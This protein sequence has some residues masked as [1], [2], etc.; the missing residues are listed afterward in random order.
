VSTHKETLLVHVVTAGADGWGEVTAETTPAYAPDT[1][2]SARLV[3]RNELV[4]R[5]FAGASFDA[6]R[7]N[8]AAI[9]ALSGALLDAQLRTDEISLASYLGSTRTRVDAGVAIG[10]SDTVAEV[11]AEAREHVGLGYRSLKLKVEPGADIDVV[12]AVRA[13]VGPGVTIQV[14]ANGSYTLDDADR[15]SALD[16]LDVACFEQPLA[17]D[18]LLDHARLASRLRTPIGLDETITSARVARDAIELG[19]CAVVSIKAGLVGGLAE[20]RRT[21]DACVDSGIAARAGGMLETGLGRAALI[22][23]AA[24]PGFT[25]TGDLSASS[26][27]FDH[28]I[29]EPIELDHGGLLVPSGPGLGVTPLPGMLA[30][31]T[32]ARER[33][34]A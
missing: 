15:L 10:R 13:E 18:A 6:V 4:P 20:A 24:L 2:D 28:D 29:T 32:V 19:A 30:R 8:H 26:R 25:V 31:H 16:A 14:D 17:P 5:V 33:W 21:H 27:Y 34:S 12:A 22:A 1:L 11:V 23:L 9:S 7:G 3:L